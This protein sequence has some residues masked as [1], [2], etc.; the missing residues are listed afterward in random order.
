MGGSVEIKLIWL[1]KLEILEIDQVGIIGM[2][3][4]SD[5]SKFGHVKLSSWTNFIS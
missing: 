3:A 4:I 1:G 5:V 2:S